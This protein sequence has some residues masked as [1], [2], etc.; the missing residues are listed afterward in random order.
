MTE[1]VRTAGSPG[2]RRGLFEETSGG[3]DRRAGAPADHYLAGRPE[4]RAERGLKPR[5]TS[6]LSRPKAG[7]TTGFK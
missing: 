3:K 1:A 2:W 6:R 4:D 7:T 5:A